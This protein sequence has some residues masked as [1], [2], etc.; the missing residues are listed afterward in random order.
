M[1]RD[2]DLVEIAP[3]AKPPVC[4]IIDFGKYQYEQKKKERKQRAKQKK[5]ELKGIRLGLKTSLHDMEIKAK[6]AEKFLS[7]GHKVQ[8]EMRLKGREKTRR[9]L[10]KEKLTKFLEMISVEIKV[11]QETKKH[12]MGLIMIIAKA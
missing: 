9:E 12:P 5:T 3:E 6:R 10:A 1:E 8:I 2:L 7:K 11:E 4:K